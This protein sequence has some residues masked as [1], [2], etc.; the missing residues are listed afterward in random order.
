MGGAAAHRKVLTGHPHPHAGLSPKLVDDVVELLLELLHS[1]LGQLHLHA[2]S[3]L[4]LQITVPVSG[5]LP[6]LTPAL[7][8]LRATAL[9]LAALFLGLGL[10]TGIGI[11]AFGWTVHGLQGAARRA[12]STLVRSRLRPHP[13]V[14]I[15]ISSSII[16][17]LLVN[18][19]RPLLL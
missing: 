15:Y 12:G 4:R 18:T 1:H 2:S 10:G 19:T 11:S 5:V 17:T 8:A 9:A 3:A 7:C 16:N 6:L 13:R 14:C